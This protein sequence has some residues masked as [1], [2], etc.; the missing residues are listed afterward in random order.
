[1]SYVIFK[2]VLKYLEFLQISV[3]SSCFPFKTVSQVM[4]CHGPYPSEVDFTDPGV[5][6][7]FAVGLRPRTGI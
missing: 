6:V 3:H 1:M 4:N 5:C 2:S 7:V